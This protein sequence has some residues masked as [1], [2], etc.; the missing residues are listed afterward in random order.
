MK[1]VVVDHAQAGR[2]AIAEVA[3]PTPEP[4]QALI[5]VHAFSLNRGEVRSAIDTAP[6]RF[7]PGWDF[8]G[9]V[10][11]AALDGSG[12]KTGARVVGMVP[13]GA[14]CELLAVAPVVLA[15]LP[16]SV[17]LLAASALPVA[18]LTAHHALKKRPKLEGARV[19]IT[20]ASG[21]VGVFA[22]QLAKRAGAKVAAAIRNPANEPL[23]RRL[24]VETAVVGS[25]L[26]SAGAAGPFDL[27]LESVGG[28]TLG[29]ALS[30]LAPGGT[31][32]VF[33]AS[34]SSV[35]TFDAR[36]FRVGGTSLYGLYLGYELQFEPPGV[37]LAHLTGLVAAGELD[38]MIEVT[39]PWTDVAHVAADL[40]GR[41]FV[42]KAVLQVKPPT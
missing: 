32:V 21:G 33:G 2:L 16:D 40:I 28:E 5:R 36:G 3:D 30:M 10:E 24:G 34:Q 4:S 13:A 14:W 18:G 7:R 41:R 35:T 27:I 38:P 29:T 42:G 22:I 6:E 11:R 19:L 37:G 31:C 12:P 8:A 26:A 23:V 9:V 20:G 25:D 1:A 39:A 17:D 15:E